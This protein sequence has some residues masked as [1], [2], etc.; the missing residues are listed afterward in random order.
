[1]M[2]LGS[3][4][5]QITEQNGLA[6]FDVDKTLVDVHCCTQFLVQLFGKRRY[7]GALQR[8]ALEHRF[9]PSQRDAV[10]LSLLRNL[11][12]G[13]DAHVF[14]EAAEEFSLWIEERLDPRSLHRLR[15]HQ[16]VGHRVMLVSASL[17]AYLR[18]MGRRLGVDHVCA[19]EM[20]ESD[21]RLTGA[22]V[23]GCNLTRGAKAAAVRDFLGASSISREEITIWAYGDSAGDAELLRFADWPIWVRLKSDTWGRC[24]APGRS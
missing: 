15:T 7:I 21:G 14:A 20:V 24:P 4:L 2:R 11:L 13:F 19:V 3:D 1:M 23:G 22:V 5:P 17:G 18:P 8:A 9:R 12:G 16:D 6:A 10:K